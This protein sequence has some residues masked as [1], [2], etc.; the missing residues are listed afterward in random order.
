MNA[1]SPA[2]GSASTAP[3]LPG[4]LADPQEPIGLLAGAGRLPV[5]IAASLQQ[6]GHRVVCV[7]IRD[8]ADPDLE[9]YC[10]QFHWTGLTKL[11]HMIRCFQR[12][13]VRRIILA[14]K[15]HK[16]KMFTPWRA[17]R[18]LPDWR[19][20]TFWLF[21]RDKRDHRD[22]ALTLQ[23]LREFER[24]GMTFEPAVTWCP[25]LLAPRGVLTRRRPN[26]EQWADIRFG[27]RLAREI[28]RLDIGQSILVK[29]RAV[30]A[31]EALEGTDRAIA[32]AGELCRAGGFTLVKVA[33]PQ[34]DLRF[35]L[36]TVGPNTIQAMHQA[37]GTVIAI[38]ADKTILVDRVATVAL[39]NRFGLIL[40]ALTDDDLL[41]S[42][43][44]R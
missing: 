30:L 18:L 2:P 39:A 4:H 12:A 13:G 40:V 27:W 37:G 31:V 42:G 43:S 25:E 6:R 21:R 41:N 24:E 11:G 3:A 14:G 36:P 1:P 33:K 35:D 26:A 32:R 5:L 17:W 16:E 34:Q 29:E 8:E 7:A 10:G 9:R 15:V 20:I 19:G 44:N 28:G 22:D 23:I 38:E